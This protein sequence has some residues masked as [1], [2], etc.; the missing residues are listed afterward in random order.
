MTFIAQRVDEPR[1]C[2]LPFL[3]RAAADGGVRQT[4]SRLVDDVRIA[5]RGRDIG[6]HHPADAAAARVEQL[7]D[8]RLQ[9]PAGEQRTD[10]Q[11]APEG[12]AVTDAGTSSPPSE[13]R[14][15]QEPAAVPSTDSGS[16]FMSIPA[17]ASAGLR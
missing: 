1:V 8:A 10:R 11:L 13:R 7:G 4:R 9:T 3:S 12:A 17:S 2:G 5:E 16:V 14:S 15:S 6:L